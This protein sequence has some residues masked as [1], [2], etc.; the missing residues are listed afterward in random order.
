MKL[1]KTKAPGLLALVAAFT[2]FA[3][4]APL[5]K[6]L[7]T[8]GATLGVDGGKAISYCNVFFIGNV[9]AALLLAGWF[10]FGTLVQD[11][12]GLSPRAWFW[13]TLASTLSVAVSTLMYQALGA[14]TVANVVLLSRVGPLLFALVGSVVF[15]TR[16]SRAEWVGNGFVLASLL[17]VVFSQ[18]GFSMNPGDFLALES[19]VFYCLTTIAGRFAVRHAGV[20]PYMLL[21]NVIAAIVFF[22]LAIQMFGLHHFADAFQPRLW[23]VVTAYAAVAVVLAQAAWYFALDR[24]DPVQV[25][26]FS[27]VSP[28]MGMVFGLV[29]L[30][31]QPIAAQWVALGLTAVG[32]VIGSVFKAWDPRVETPPETAVAAR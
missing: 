13:V 23:L 14:T 9:S 10:G 11:V 32:A 3:L 17:L 21:R 4:A 1:D 15:G 31:E 28:A 7:A 27:I 29:L 24:V 8:H 2:C 30:D 19:G 22:V 26:S 25:G 20:R 6:W 16:I 18:G 5:T 12:K